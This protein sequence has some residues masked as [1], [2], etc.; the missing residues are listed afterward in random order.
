MQEL[1][2]VIVP[3]YNTEKYLNRCVDSIIA[4]TYKN[5][6]VYLIDDGSNDNS[7]LICDEYQ[8]KDNRIKVIH[9]ENG[10]QGVARNVAL[11][12]CSGE[13]IYFVDSDDW[14]EK[15]A[16]ELMLKS[17]KENNAQICVCGVNYYNG[18]YSRTKIIYQDEKI[19]SGEEIL[20]EYLTTTNIGCTLWDKLYHKSLFDNVRFP[21]LRSTEDTYLMHTLLGKCKRAVYVPKA[22][23]V[24]Y[25]RPGSTE[26]SRFSLK[27]MALIDANLNLQKYIETNHPSLYPV[28]K[29]KYINSLEIILKRI[30]GDF[31]YFKY[32]DTYSDVLKKLK[33]E[34]DRLIK[35]GYKD[36]YIERCLYIINN[37][38]MFIIKESLNGIKRSSK[39]I[40]KRTYIAK[41]KRG[42]R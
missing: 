26:N 36:E 23:Y 22:L 14:I 5:I 3:V 19:F 18:A 20:L 29:Y 8:K 24:Q 34:T 39:N 7:G 32:R 33:D 42:I 40:I 17:C 25:I 2:S 41:I 38:K 10:G 16:I 4:Q 21:N 27:K 12:E 11:D 37:Q 13:Y 35:N 28:V 6:E 15:N 9:K 1:I 30:I 31:V